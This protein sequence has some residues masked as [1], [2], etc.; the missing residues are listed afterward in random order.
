VINAAVVSLPTPAD[1]EPQLGFGD[2]PMYAH[3][4]AGSVAL[5][6]DEILDRY[7]KRAH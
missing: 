7:Y 1:P 3:D 4:R 2:L 5:A 6:R